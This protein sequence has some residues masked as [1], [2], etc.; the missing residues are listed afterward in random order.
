MW[1]PKIAGH[2]PGSSIR[3]VPA[4]SWEECQQLCCAALPAC[5][6]II[7]NEECYLL[8]RKYEGN[9]GPGGGFV[10][11]L[12]CTAGRPPRCTPSPPPPQF[13]AVI[14]VS[15]P[16]FSTASRPGA[17]A[18]KTSSVSFFENTGTF[19]AAGQFY[20]NRTSGRVLVS[21][22]RAPEQAVFGVTQTLLNVA[23][24]H[25]I[26]WQNVSF[27]H[28][29]WSEPS[30]KG[31]VERYGNVLTPIGD[32]KG[33]VMTPA[34]VMVANATRVSFEECTFEQLGAWGIRLFNATQDA[35]VSRCTFNDLS[36][37]GV[38][39]GNTDDSAE[40]RPQY[41]TP[42]PFLNIIFLD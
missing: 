2:S 1:G 41:V 16:C 18:L 36:G 37:G 3:K 14:N 9:Y 39:L 42:I 6:A 26:T 31:F 35:V 7:F 23:G 28:S 30:T 8:D 33:L 15:T 19:T 25:D 17:L 32:E 10:A 34:A 38:C 11:D 5:Q 24:A 13:S 12:N 22:E 29:G 21:G 40:T 4:S 20:V 27:M